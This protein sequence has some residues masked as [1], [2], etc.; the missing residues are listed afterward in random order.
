MNKKKEKSAYLRLYETLRQGIERGD[1]SKKL[2]SKREMAKRTG[3]SVVTVEHA[4]ALL[5]D[6]GFITAQ[7][8][9]GYFVTYR[10]Q[11]SFPV[12]GEVLPVP[13]A[14]KETA[15][16]FPF[17]VL[18]R[19]MRRVL[20]DYGEAILRKPP[21]HGTAELRG[22]IARYLSR[23]RDI[24]VQSD[25]I[26]VGSGAEALYGLILQALGQARR[27]AIEDPSYAKIA[28][29]YQAYG[30]EPERLK[31]AENGISSQA[32]NGCQADILH[33]SPYRSY[34][35]GV[36]ASA[37]KKKE[38]LQWASL[39]GRLLIE[40]DF[41][42]EFAASLKPVDALF[43]LT[44]KENVLY[45]NTFSQTIAPSFRTGYLVL[46][47]RLAKRFEDTVGFY[48]CTVPTFEQL[49]LAQLL[50]GGDF[51]RHL[52]RVRRKRRKAEQ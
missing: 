38:Y 44:E 31:L 2:P 41:E 17:T 3:V 52:N 29:V 22:A 13:P 46:P 48:S 20:T 37:A 42:S 24:H 7:E 40:D 28:Q 25:Q 19:T 8:K 23:S 35:S 5:A 1:Y 15:E 34:P 50:D 12:G 6:E 47:P 49:V 11:D 26:W 21:R 30:V 10:A 27:Y 36:T 14:R 43:A 18:A 4:Y 16:H 45:L 9:R 32:L 39:P 51:E 33:V